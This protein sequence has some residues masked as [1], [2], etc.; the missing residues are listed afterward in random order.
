[1]YLGG[2]KG[3]EGRRVSRG[4][5]VTQPGEPPHEDGPH[6]LAGSEDLRIGQTIAD[7]SP[8]ADRLHE[9]DGS[10]RR[11]VL[12]G[13]G[14]VQAELAGDLVDFGRLGAKQMQDP[15]A[16][17]AGQRPKHRGLELIDVMR[18][19]LTL[20]R[21]PLASMRRAGR[22]SVGQVPASAVAVYALWANICD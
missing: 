18:G 6:E 12:G 22:G 17:R 21:A 16:M 8:V 2:W 3:R 1:M 7:G 5:Q 19:A 20:H 14:L 11:K 4:G 15:Q 10:H 13:R 9:A